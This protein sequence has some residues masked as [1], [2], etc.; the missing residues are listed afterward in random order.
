MIRINLLGQA[1]PKPAGKGVPVEATFRLLLLA[2]A[3]GIAFIILTITYFRES[4]QL[5]EVNRR[6]SDLQSERGRLQQVKSQV[7]QFERQKAV[8]QQRINVIETLQKNRAGG[9]ELLTMV[10]NTVVRSET[11]WLTSLGRKG[12]TL[13]FEGEAGSINA[14][15]NFLTQ[16]KRTGYFDKVE[17]KEAKENDIAKGTQTFLFTLSADIASSPPP[18]TSP[19]GTPPPGPAKGR[20]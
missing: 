15:A 9:Q 14:V 4:R 20:S 16:M 17:L 11:V 1:R 18:E 10:A 6:I 5:D 8:L 12:N 19:A 2:A 3:L 7:E 13:E